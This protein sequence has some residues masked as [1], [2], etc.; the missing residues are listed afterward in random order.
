MRPDHGF[1]T[2]MRGHLLANCLGQGWAALMA[3]AFVPVYLRVLGLEA[4]GVVGVF[5]FMQTLATL[6]D[7]GMTPMVNREMARH[8][9]GERSAQSAADLLKT[10]L[11]LVGLCALV[12]ALCVGL[13]A[14]WITREWLR[15]QRLDR[16]EA[17]VAI[18]AIGALV[19]LRLLEGVYRGALLGLHQAVR[20]NTVMAWS[21]TVR[22][23]GAAAA[24]VW[25]SPRL[26]LFFAWQAAVSMATTVLLRAQVRRCLPSGPL[27]AK[28]SWAALSGVWRFAGGTLALTALGLLLTQADKLILVRRLSLET[29]GLYSAAWTAAAALYQLVVPLT[30]TYFP[31][32]TALWARSDTQA[33]A[34][35][36]H[37][38]ARLMALCLLP[39]ALVLIFFAEALLRAWLGDAAVAAA[40]APVLSFLALGVL[41]NGLLHVPHTLAMA[42]GWVRFGLGANAIAVLL[43]FPVLLWWSG[44]A[45]ATGAAGAWALLHTSYLLIGMLFFHRTLLPQEKWIWYRRDVALPL[46]AATAACLTLRWM[47]KDPAALGWL[48]L[49]LIGVGLAAVLLVVIPDARAYWRATRRRKTYE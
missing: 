21:A 35:A 23:G 40:A 37:Q 44:E 33:L 34:S 18:A 13:G 6:L 19:A 28:I 26:D 8:V 24:I 47:I 12:L 30:Q 1:L 9:A 20:L 11:A 32:F 14:E 46:A 3:V 31:R 43:Y 22:W 42:T 2:T 41:M 49:S 10:T 38:A 48:P 25:I 16:R 45:G 29:F 36:Y 15:P 27:R 5:L 4:Y 7:V 39:P 17:A